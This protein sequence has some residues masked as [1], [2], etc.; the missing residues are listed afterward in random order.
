[1]FTKRRGWG[2]GQRAHKGRIRERSGNRN[3]RAK[4]KGYTE[5][6]LWRRA[7]HILIYAIPA[8]LRSFIHSKALFIHSASS[9]IV[10]S[11]LCSARLCS[12]GWPP[13][14]ILEALHSVS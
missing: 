4:G 9:S 7:V 13:T 1:M 14:S 5:I 3:W 2:D 8:P 12:T 10:S 6:L 11:L